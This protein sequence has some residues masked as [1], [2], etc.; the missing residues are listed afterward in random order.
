MDDA[1]NSLTR[2]SAMGAALY[3]LSHL[4]VSKVGEF[5]YFSAYCF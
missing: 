4:A 1:I 2:I 3:A 5:L